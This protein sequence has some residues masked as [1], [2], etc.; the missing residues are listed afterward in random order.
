M[1]TVFVIKQ[2]PGTVYITTPDYFSQFLRD[3]QVTQED[4]IW[5]NV[6]LES[7]IMLKDR[8]SNYLVLNSMTQPNKL[9]N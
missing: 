5:N 4:V 8:Q 2:N 1:F 7:L 9:P 3:M 6:S